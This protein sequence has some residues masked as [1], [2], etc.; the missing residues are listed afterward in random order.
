MKKT[1]N[2]FVR[3]FSTNKNKK[4]KERLMKYQSKI[5]IFTENIGDLNKKILSSG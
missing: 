4:K 3:N 2:L 5:K 1:S